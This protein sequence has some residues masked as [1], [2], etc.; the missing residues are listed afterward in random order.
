MS[1][2]G[3][4]RYVV[5]C[6]WLLV[7]IFVWNVVFARFLPPALLS[8][9]LSQ[10]IP[11]LVAYG[12]NTLRIVVMV[13]PFLM[14]LEV[15]M[16]SQRRGVWLFAVGTIVYCLAWV[17]L[18]VVPHSRWSTS[19]LGFV[20]PAYTPLV[21]LVGLGLIGRRLFVPSPFRWWMY[22]AVACAFI[23]FHVAHTSIVYAHYRPQ[24]VVTAFGISPVVSD[25]RI[26]PVA[27]EASL[28]RERRP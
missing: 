14:P 16:V 2:T 15:T 11:P 4:V 8:N 5:N 21:W 20:A 22:V 12:E 19:W 10:D 23:M 1:E 25:E 26:L 17:P 13:L 6:G 27:V 18:M 9:E 28:C 24:L 7:P 3:L